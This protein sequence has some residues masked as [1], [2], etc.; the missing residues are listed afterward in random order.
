LSSVAAASAQRWGGEAQAHATGYAQRRK[1][2]G[3]DAIWRAKAFMRTCCAR[4]FHTTSPAS[5]SSYWFSFAHHF[6]FIEREGIDFHFLFIFSDIFLL[7]LPFLLR[8][9]RPSRIILLLLSL[10][11]PLFHILLSAFARYWFRFAVSSSSF[12]AFIDISLI[13]RFRW[14]LTLSP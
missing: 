2:R 5:T 7:S 8:S 14:L 6:S 4:Y 12:S 1:I 11:I 13:F 3:Y 9:L 10:F